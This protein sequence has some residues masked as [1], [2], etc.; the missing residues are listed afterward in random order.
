MNPDGTP[1]EVSGSIQQFDPNN[2]EH[3]LFN[4]W[5][6]EI[7]QMGGSPILYY[8][9]FISTANIDPLYLEARD[10]LFSNNPVQLWG[11][12]E[13]IRSQNQMTAFGFDSPDEMQFEMNYRAVLTALG[14]M[15]RIG[16]RLHTPHLRE[17]WQ[18]IQC[19]R[20]EFKLWGALRVQIIAK[21][22][23][24]TVTTGEGKVTQIKEPFKII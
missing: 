6:Q 24:E 20:G 16:S 9:V 4:L 14:H 2:Q 3:D 13:P 1:Y 7:I 18:I 21:R 22:F 5:D 8:E 11:L 19:N 12:Y 10:K 17:D 15:P 23:Q